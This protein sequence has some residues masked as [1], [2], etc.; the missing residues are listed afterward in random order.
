MI[1]TPSKQ[2][3]LHLLF[4]ALGSAEFTPLTSQFTARGTAP[5]PIEPTSDSGDLARSIQ[6]A[7]APSEADRGAWVIQ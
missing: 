5:I 1:K 6:R 2:L 3:Q 7:A 4:V